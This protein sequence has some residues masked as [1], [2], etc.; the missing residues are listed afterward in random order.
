MAAYELNCFIFCN[1]NCCFARDDD[2]DPELL[3]K[4]RDP[5]DT[6][7]WVDDAIEASEAVDADRLVRPCIKV[8]GRRLSELRPSSQRRTSGELGA[9]WVLVDVVLVLLLPFTGVLFCL[10]L[11]FTDIMLMLFVL[12]LFM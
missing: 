4:Y 5:D 12:P 10:L 3:P 11:L 8:F 2:A 1:S 6:D 7:D 9:L